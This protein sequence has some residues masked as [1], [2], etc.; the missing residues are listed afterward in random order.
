V[1]TFKNL[2]NFK[3]K[4]KDIK[5]ILHLKKQNWKYTLNSQYKYFQENVKS[6]DI[7]CL[8]H[9]K[10]KLVGYTLLR[11]RKIFNIK[12]LIFDTYIID[13]KFRLKGYG[14]ELL[15]YD[16]KIIKKKKLPSILLCKKSMVNFYKSYG[17]LLSN[18]KVKKK[19]LM[20]FNLKKKDRVLISKKYIKLISL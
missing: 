5:S 15:R 7:H 2:N 12:F 17:W 16:N 8:M 10:E 11:L 20:Y 14:G 6:N 9:I 13:K 19:K 4:K 18:S 1:I 3:V